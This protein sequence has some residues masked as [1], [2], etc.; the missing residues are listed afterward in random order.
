MPQDDLLKVRENATGRELTAVSA[1]SVPI[2]TG[3]YAVDKDPTLDFTDEDG[4][5]V[6][7]RASDI[8]GS[9]DALYQRV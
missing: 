1:T 5:P 7:V 3:D 9:P 6:E 8:G 2:S 4:N